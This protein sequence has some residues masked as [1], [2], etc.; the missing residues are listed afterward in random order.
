MKSYEKKE[1]ELK[2]RVDENTETQMVKEG[3]EQKEGIH[4]VYSTA[5]HDSFSCL[6]YVT[7]VSVLFSLQSLLSLYSLV[8]KGS[9]RCW[10]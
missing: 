10:H 7:K 8:G 2:H 4:R 5:R 6:V 9:G 1:R 3:A